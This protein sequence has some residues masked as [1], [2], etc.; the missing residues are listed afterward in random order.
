AMKMETMLQYNVDHTGAIKQFAQGFQDIGTYGCSIH[1]TMWKEEREPRT[2]ISK[3][4]EYSLL[5]IPLGP[6]KEMKRREIRLTY[7]GNELRSLDPFMFFPD[8]TVSMKDVNKKG[9]FVFWR[10]FP[11]KH[12]IRLQEAN[13]TMMWTR[14][15]T[16]ETP[17]NVY[18]GDSQRALKSEGDPHPGRDTTG[19]LRGDT[20]GRYQ[21]DQGTIWIVPR[22]LGIGRSDRPEMWIVSILNKAQIVQLQPFDHDHGLHPVS[23]A[24]PY[25]MGYG[26]GEAGLM[27]Y[28]GPIQDTISWYINSRTDNVRKALND[29]FVV[30]PNAIEMQDLKNPKPG[31]IIRLKRSAIGLDVRSVVHQLEVKDV[32]RSHVADAQLFMK[33]SQFLSAVNDNVM[34]IQEFGGR[35]TATEIR[36]AGEG[37]V[38]RLAALARLISAQQMIPTTK[39]MS[40]NVMQFQ[41]MD[42]YLQILGQES[43]QGPQIIEAGELVGDYWYP[44]HDGTL[45]LDRVAM[46]DVWKEILGLVLQSEYLSQRYDAGKVFEHVAELGGA[47][48]IKNMQIKQGGL[49]TDEDVLNG[50]QAGNLVPAA[51]LTGPSG[52]VNAN[53]ER[54]ANRANGGLQ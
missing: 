44:V 11:G 8:P 38:S 45:P 7:Q 26:F 52:L 28:V 25:G 46:L 19:E 35:K 20:A 24:E 15:S 40:L 49:R 51:S 14:A 48:N 10:S 13:G 21:L 42:F 29:M 3:E 53:P 41:D 23:V 9:E 34:G 17:M 33:M 18:E 4:S 47:K 2:V 50:L 32:T 22:E 1:G 12:E 30:D 5:G 6:K 54:A 36:T 16:S 37:G 39:Q 27:D 43:E 31:K